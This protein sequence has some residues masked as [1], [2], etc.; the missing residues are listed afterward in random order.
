MRT[1][2]DTHCDTQCDTLGT[3]CDITCVYT[4]Y[5]IHMYVYVYIT[6]IVESIFNIC[7]TV[8]HNNFILHIYYLLR[9]VLAY[10]HA[11]LRGDMREGFSMVKAYLE[12]HLFLKR[13]SFSHFPLSL[14]KLLPWAYPSSLC[15]PALYTYEKMKW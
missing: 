6:D 14:L 10:C 9:L 12:Q 2:Y 15:S 11:K 1:N 4:I 7:C 3:H 8:Q 5:Y 13:E